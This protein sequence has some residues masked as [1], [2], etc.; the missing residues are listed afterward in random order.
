MNT[1]SVAVVV[2][3]VIVVGLVAL[4]ALGSV[5]RIAREYERFIVFRLGRTLGAKGPGMVIL[6]P[7]LDRAVK[8]DLR[9]QFMEKVI[10]RLHEA[11]ALH[12]L[13]RLTEHIAG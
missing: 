10:H 1:L 2:F 12:R 4:G 13:E 5:V 8:V 6:L 7:L 11:G 3:L 9:E